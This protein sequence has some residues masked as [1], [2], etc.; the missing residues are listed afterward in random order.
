MVSSDVSTIFVNIPRHFAVLLLF[1]L[2]IILIRTI[3]FSI[4]KFR[5]K[6]KPMELAAMSGKHFG[7]GYEVCT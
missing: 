6:F 3:A 1:F 7:K 4:S 2:E 5:A